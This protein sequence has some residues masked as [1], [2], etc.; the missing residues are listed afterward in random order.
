MQLRDSPFGHTSLLCEG[1]ERHKFEVVSY[2][3]GFQTGRQRVDRRQQLHGHFVALH[4]AQTVLQLHQ[5]AI[6]QRIA[7]SSAQIP[8]SAVPLTSWY[9]VADSCDSTKGDEDSSKRASA[10]HVPDLCS[11]S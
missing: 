11:G 6:G 9:D 2:H 8:M 1:S 10:V 3:E 4:E 5:R 7:L